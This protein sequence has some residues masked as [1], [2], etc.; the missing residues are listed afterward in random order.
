MVTEPLISTLLRSTMFNQE[1]LNSSHQSVL[2]VR[3]VNMFI[4]MEINLIT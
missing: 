4:E 1:M 3:T 2:K